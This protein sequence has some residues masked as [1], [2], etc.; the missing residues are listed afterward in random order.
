ME[1]LGYTEGEICNRSGCTGTIATHPAENC[2]CHINPPCSACTSPRNFCAACDWQEKDDP[3]V[4]EEVHTYHLAINGGFWGET[5]KRVL[6]PTKI[7]WIVQ[8]HSNSSQKCIGV[9][10][11]GTSRAEVDA[12]VKGTFGGRFD[13]FGGGHFQY[14]AYTD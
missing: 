11:E 2:S 12:R 7:D 1:A 13:T 6:D 10:P 3:L 8:S 4:V 14:I 9:Y 5:R